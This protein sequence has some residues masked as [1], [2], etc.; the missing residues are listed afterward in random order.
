MTT[1]LMPLFERLPEIHRT[2]DGDPERHQLKAFLGLIDEAFSAIHDDIWH[3][4]DDLFVE[5]ASDW[6]IPYIG[7][8]LG[9]THLAGEPWTIRADVADTIALRRRKG[10]LAAIELLTFDL[11]G[12]GIHAV[13]L[14][15]NLAWSQH[16]N[17]LRPDL[18]S[19]L[20]VGGP[21]GPGPGLAAPQWGGT[22]T[23]RDPA[24]LSLIGTPFDPF[25]HLA[26]VRP[27]TTGAIRYNLPNLAIFLWRLV[28]YRVKESRPG[29]IAVRTPTL[30]SGAPP[31]A[32]KRLVA[33]DVDPLGRPIRLFNGGGA[34]RSQRL[35]CCEPGETETSSLT[36]LDQAP[37]P[38]LPARLTDDTPAG[39]PEAYVSVDAYDASSGSIVR[40][41]PEALQLHVPRDRFPDE[42][43]Q[44][45]GA[46]LCAWE[47][48]LDAPLLDREIAIDPVIGRVLIGV[49][50]PGEAA[51]LRRQLL[52]PFTYGAVGPVGAHPVQRDEAPEDWNEEPVTIVSVRHDTS[53]TALQDALGGLDAIKAPMVIE[54]EDSYV[55]D[56]DLAA[57][58][59]TKTE[60]GG[61][62]LVLG[63]TVIIRAADGHRPI[64]RLKRPL[65][66]RPAE[67]VAA[68]PAKQ[69]DVDARNDHL[70]LHLQGLFLTRGKGF[71]AGDPLVARVALNALVIDGCS[72]DPGG[73]RQL[74]GT[75]A[76]LLPS[77]DLRTDHGFPAKSEE[78]TAFGQ[79]PRVEIR[80]SIVGAI[81]ADDDYEL[82]IVDSI[83]D[84]GTGPADPASV[85]AIGSATDPIN[86]W[87][88]PLNVD[89]AT[90]LGPVRVERI[91][92]DRPEKAGFARGG[93]WTHALQVHDDQHGCIKLSRFA[94]VGDRL[95]Q[96]V[97]C[98]SGEG[99]RL[100]FV[101][102]AFGDAAYGQ[103]ARTCD[104]RI[105]E[106]GPDDDEMGA[107]GRLREAHKWRNLQIRYREFMP[108]G[109]RPLLI[110]AT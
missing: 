55:H 62:N 52:V 43:W 45:R 54:I 8:L 25:A 30:G 76:P 34:S 13:E 103:L 89:R 104:F 53:T 57:V 64:I 63:R 19:G 51:A 28:P 9:T 88:A 36:E 107:Y 94:G 12:W 83:V 98:V 31:N 7:D 93:I 85:L 21:G 108:L 81:R 35:G 65:R 101:S 92:P 16:L 74:D 99:A 49:A 15:E 38:I 29:T 109:I 66:V 39:H 82:E 37:G 102:I 90:F 32:A 46:N 20:G 91:A 96:N 71:P 33:L 60:A 105:L 22:V 47:A 6:A 3:L 5:T 79:T 42:P 72:L 24:V 87:G 70:E 10:T 78:A 95:P 110:P 14:R 75:R 48:G 17:H 18:A 77:I 23:L 67:V 50:K 97:E 59:G 80:S 27:P 86:D 44:F 2:R 84:A 26:D 100:R 4:Y 41:L 58:A 40:D 68:P 106:R 61:P 73:H 11:T 56:L 1:R 69:G